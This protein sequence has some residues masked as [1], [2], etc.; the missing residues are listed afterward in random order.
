MLG[1]LIPDLA[2]DKNLSHYRYVG[3]GGWGTP[4]LKEAKQDLWK[5][6][7]AKLGAYCHLLLD[8]HF[9]ANYLGSKYRLSDD[10][11]KVLSN[12]GSQNW[13]VKVFLS[14]DGLY[15][16]YSHFNPNLVA[17]SFI[18]K[19]IFN[20][21]EKAPLIGLER[22]DERSGR[23]WRTEIAKYLSD[24]A[25]NAPELFTYTEL[26]TMIEEGAKLFLHELNTQSLG[27]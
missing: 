2:K 27:Q 9:F 15:G 25:L 7:P 3:R 18:P 1:N 12:N 10:G 22:F 16:C 20:L 5:N 6:D 21:S 26:K 13:P 4:D 11:T 23:N 19:Q 24:P 8:Y 17:D 14:N